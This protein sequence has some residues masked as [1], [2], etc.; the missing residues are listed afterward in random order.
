MPHDRL[1]ET[2]HLMFTLVF[3][4]P[5]VSCEAVG[6]DLELVQALSR[7]WDEP[8]EHRTGRW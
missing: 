6:S 1:A 8:C 2:E 3:R 7:P 5:F 4:Y